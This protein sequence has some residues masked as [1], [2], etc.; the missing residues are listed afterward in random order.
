MR[1]VEQAAP[2]APIEYQLSPENI[3]FAAAWAALGRNEWSGWDAFV[4][5]MGTT[6]AREE[7]IIE[8][9]VAFMSRLLP[10]SGRERHAIARNIA[11]RIEATTPPLPSARTS[12]RTRIRIGVLSPDFR[13][14]LNA[15][16][17]LPLFDLLDRTR[18]EIHAFSLAPDDGSAIRGRLR[19]AADAFR[20]LGT[21][22]DLEAASAICADGIDILVDLSGH[23]TGGRFA[24][25]AQRPAPLQVNYLGF[26]CSFASQRIDYAIVDRVVGS[27]DTEWTE[28]RVYLPET[29]FLYDF[30]AEPP[31]ASVGRHDYGLPEDAFVYCAFHRAEKISP[32]VFT[33]WMR[34]LAEVPASVLWFRGLSDRSARNLQQAAAEHCVASRR[35]I[36]APFEPSRDPRYLARHALGDLMLDSLHHNAMTSAC[37]ALGMGLPLLTLPGN[38]M[39]A[40]AGESLV[41]AAGLPEL[42]ARDQEEYVRIAVQ[43]AREPDSLQALKDRLRANRRTAPLFDTAGRV[44]ALEAAFQEMYDRMMRGE[45][46]ASFDVQA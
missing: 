8:P 6:A 4:E 3:Y 16:H 22:S 17:L 11:R 44:R 15:Y 27:D 21:L 45:P 43:L 18:F 35:L 38:A 32:D 19:G 20:D 13:E 5:E 25:T 26:S 29:H 7:T 39:A 37:D 46:P 40:R 12:R 36:F 31:P 41:R 23:T 34:I 42:V 2:G 9:A 14:H 1:F 10:L 28:S 30:R 24:I 33:L